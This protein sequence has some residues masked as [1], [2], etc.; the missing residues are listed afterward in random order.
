MASTV[1]PQA[2]SGG[3]IKSVQR[4]LASSSGNI[5]ITSVNISKSS[6]SKK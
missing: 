2:S 5:T 4:G 3:G 1:Y 6:S